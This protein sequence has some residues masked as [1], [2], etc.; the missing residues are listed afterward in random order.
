MPWEVF[1]LERRFFL[2]GHP[3]LAVSQAVLNCLF[4]TDLKH[5]IVYTQPTR[6]PLDRLTMW[7]YHRCWNAKQILFPCRGLVRGGMMLNL[8]M[9]RT[10]C[11]G[12]TWPGLS[13]ARKQWGT[14]PVPFTRH[15]GEGRQII[16]KKRGDLSWCKIHKQ[17]EI[18]V[19]CL[20][21]CV[22]PESLM[23]DFKVLGYCSE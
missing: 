9:L 23:R 2:Y 22:D 1:T 14:G 3:G 21:T 20:P 15:R 5:G 8:L 4:N 18:F 6:K 17:T 10:A 7:S 13:W 19:E 16:T 11:T 12:H